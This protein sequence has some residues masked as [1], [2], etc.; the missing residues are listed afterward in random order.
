MSSE[1]CISPQ[2]H[3]DSLEEHSLSH[4]IFHLMKH[5]NRKWAFLSSAAFCLCTS[6]TRALCSPAVAPAVHVLFCLC[7]LSNLQLFLAMCLV[8]R[9]FLCLSLLVLGPVRSLLQSCAG[10]LRALS[11]GPQ[12]QA[13]GFLWF[14]SGAKLR[15]SPPPSPQHTPARH[16]FTLL[17][18]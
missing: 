17:W 6:Y 4:E 5:K 10:F 16:P 3:Q 14:I 12:G 8:L 2:G 7:V 1:K 11:S 15:H 9:M 18:K 13:C